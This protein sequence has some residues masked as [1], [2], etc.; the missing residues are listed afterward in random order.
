MRH[1]HDHAVHDCSARLVDDGFKGRDEHFTALQAKPF[2]MT[3]FE[4]RS[5][6]TCAYK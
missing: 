1:S 6:Q 5:L 3:T 4:P 2:L